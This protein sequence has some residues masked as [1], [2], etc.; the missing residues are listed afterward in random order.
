MAEK[1]KETA[2]VEV[3]TAYQLAK[4][5]FPRKRISLAVR[6]SRNTDDGLH[7]AFKN[8][9]GELKWEFYTDTHIKFL[10]EKFGAWKF[11]PM[12][13]VIEDENGHKTSE[14]GWAFFIAGKESGQ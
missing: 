11:S 5:L 1:A 7:V 4:K 12:Q 6:Q 13:C 8:K 2:H 10:M 14:F 9:D 3:Y